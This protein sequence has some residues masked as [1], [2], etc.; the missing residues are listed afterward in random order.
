M[1]LHEP[2]AT[3]S[4]CT[5][6][7]LAQLSNPLEFL[8]VYKH[9]QYQVDYRQHFPLFTESFVHSFATSTNSPLPHPLFHPHSCLLAMKTRAK[10]KSKHPAAPIMTPRQ[11]A[12]AGIPQPLTRPRRQPTKDQRIAALEHQQNRFFVKV[13]KL[14][15]A[16]KVATK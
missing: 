7:T 8:A 11:L 9:S 5:S 10:N 4:R 12:A 1:L 3:P 2:F 15:K 16:R 13:G 6:I 14:G